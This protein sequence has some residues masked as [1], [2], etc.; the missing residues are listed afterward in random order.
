MP[1]TYHHEYVPLA[2][3]VYLEVTHFIQCFHFVPQ[4]VWLALYYKFQIKK[5]QD[6]ETQI[7]PVSEGCRYDNLP[8]NNDTVGIAATLGFQWPLC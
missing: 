2:I 1:W 5:N 6:S 7:T 3:I 4:K 8:L